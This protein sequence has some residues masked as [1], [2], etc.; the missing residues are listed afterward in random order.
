MIK[1]SIRFV[2]QGDI[3]QVVKLCGKHAAFEKA[4]Y[5]VAGKAKS[6]EK[7]LF[8]RTP[9]L[10]CFIAENDTEIYGFAT[11]MLQYSTW[12]ATEYVYLDCLFLQEK[13]RGFGI[14]EEL[15]KRIQQEAKILGC[16][17]IQWQTPDFNKRAIKFYKRIGAASKSKE[18]F[19]LD[20]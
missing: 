18:R 14:G 16:S 4:E 15:M 5:S 9:S 1:Y 13:A 12:D 6:L 8:S 10:F 11:Y 7:A 2:E 3:P 17:H 20:V 19:F